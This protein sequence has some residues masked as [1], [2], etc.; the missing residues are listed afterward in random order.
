MRT[1][2]FARRTFVPAALTLIALVTVTALGEA[3]RIPAV[4]RPGGVPQHVNYAAA[5]RSRI[6]GM[7]QFLSSVEVSVNGSPYAKQVVAP[8]TPAFPTS[9]PSNTATIR[10]SVRWT[11]LP[12]A[13]LKAGGPPEPQ[14]YIILRATRRPDGYVAWDSV[15]YATT[16]PATVQATLSPASNALFRVAPALAEEQMQHTASSA[17]SIPIN[18]IV[19]VRTVPDTSLAA[20]VI[21]P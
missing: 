20:R 3:Q 1:P 17:G 11:P 16:S 12:T 19:T 15:A 5:A 10:V 9:A 13:E 8:G 4:N 18:K 21:T 7:D 14:G 6:V 2:G